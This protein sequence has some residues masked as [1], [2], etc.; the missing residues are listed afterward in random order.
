MF[1]YISDKK[2]VKYTT[3]L[4]LNSIKDY[5]KSFTILFQN[6]NPRRLASFGIIPIKEEPTL[7]NY[8]ATA[9]SIDI[10]DDSE[11]QDQNKKHDDTTECRK[12]S[13]VMF[14]SNDSNCTL[15]R[16]A[17][18]SEQDSAC[19]RTEM[20]DMATL[21]SRLVTFQ[22]WPDSSL[23]S[24]VPLATFG[25]YYT[26]HRDNVKCFKCGLEIEG[27]SE[28]DDPEMMHRSKNPNCPLLI[29]STHHQPERMISNDKAQGKTVWND[30]KNTNKGNKPETGQTHG[31]ASNYYIPPE[32]TLTSNTQRV[33]SEAQLGHKRGATHSVMDNRENVQQTTHLPKM[34]NGRANPGDLTRQLESTNT[35]TH[36]NNGLSNGSIGNNHTEPE[37][38]L[39]TNLP[40]MTNVRPVRGNSSE[41]PTS[42]P[43]R[44]TAPNSIS[45][46]PNN[47][48]PGSGGHNKKPVVLRTTSD[49][50]N[51]IVSTNTTTSAEN[52]FSLRDTTE[53]I[54]SQPMDYTIE[55]NRLASFMGNWSLDCCV[56]P[57]ELAAAGLYYTGK[58]LKAIYWYQEDEEMF[59]CFNLSKILKI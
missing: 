27:W 35:Y 17:M 4:P 30:E 20:V 9:K 44:S 43:Q 23:V 21:I 52:W 13:T 2:S 7:L 51:A 1:L 6:L 19:H 10:K 14:G 58:C 34:T 8:D 49:T 36:E 25:Y 50:L 54:T 55:T 53:S 56:Q 31:G 45:V 18:G 41:I 40:R 15:A 29:N 48:P 32:D 11:K 24:T 3:Y 57:P 12:K 37:D 47:L 39:R 22:H 46:K 42:R 26:G 38:T 59:C 33:T 5:L 28:T 16:A